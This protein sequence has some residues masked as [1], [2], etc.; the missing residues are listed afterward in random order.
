MAKQTNREKANE[1]RAKEKQIE[2]GIEKLK[3]L[4][5]QG[6]EM[7][8]L[9][10]PAKGKTYLEP[11][12]YKEAGAKYG[13]GPEKARK[14]VSFAKKYTQR[15]L[16]QLIAI[17]EKHQ[18]V[19]GFDLIVQLLSVD[20]KSVRK[21]LQIDAAKEKWAKDRLRQ[22]MKLRRATPA[23]R[24][25]KKGQLF[26][27]T[28]RGKHPKA[29]GSIDALVGELLSDAAKWS[30]LIEILRKIDSDGQDLL[31]WDELPAGLRTDMN[32]LEKVFRKFVKHER[33]CKDHPARS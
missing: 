29:I 30:R 2:K 31:K 25:N 10:K 5:S 7:K 19:I 26:D 28:R 11:N 21:Q 24:E 18:R 4:Y 23:M 9:L 1:K 8:K 27:P 3:S 33:L 13:A 6:A 12:A 16:N 32:A 22:V 17:C 15:D 20:D 14:M